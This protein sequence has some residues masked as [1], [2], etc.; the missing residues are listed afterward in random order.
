[1]K[2]TIIG[3]GSIFTPLL[4]D[5][6]PRFA[7]ELPIDEVALL[8]IDLGA[9]QRAAT[10]ARRSLS[11]HGARLPEILPTVDPREAIESSDF[12]VITIR[13]GGLQARIQD[14][15]VPLRH[16][17]LGDE[18][19]GP[20]GFSNALRTIPVVVDYARQIER[21]APQAWVI[22]FTNPEGLLT[23]AMTRHSSVRAIGLCTAPYGLRLAGAAYL[24]VEPARVRVDWIGVTH[25]SW[26][27]GIAVDGVEVLPDLVGRLLSQSSA[28]PLYPAGIVRA[29]TAYPAHLFYGLLGREAPHFYYHARRIAELQRSQGLTRGETLLSRQAEIL[30]RLETPD[31]TIEE[32]RGLRGHPI[33]EEPILSLLSA[34]HNDRD[35]IHV[36][37][38]PHGGAVQT[39]AAEAVIELPARIG[40][41]G[42][43]PLPVGPL[44][45]EVRGLMHMIK[46]Y[47]ELTIE[48]AVSGS[49][50]A[51]LRALLAHPLVMAYDVVVPLL[52]DI[53]AA[54]QPYLPPTWGKRPETAN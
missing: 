22:P 39:F 27:R 46:A 12:I 41:Q 34:L 23:E 13:V 19:T 15:K 32:L 44:P 16:G 48:A 18:T 5:G 2:L 33:L 42:A 17:I 21:W 24:G 4:L 1:M 54:N 30:H 7:D 11:G 51:A 50:A 43:Q 53:L 40:A 37:D 3:G 36:V 9:A 20:G 26:V 38:V 35:E 49:Y 28:S 25:T 6:L 31:F 10:F 14:E 29:L 52:D 47:E 8:D 45:A